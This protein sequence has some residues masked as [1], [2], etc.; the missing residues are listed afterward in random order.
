MDW[1]STFVRPGDPLI[2]GWTKL[3]PLDQLENRFI[4]PI[5]LVFHVSS[6]ALRKPLLRDLKASLANTIAKMPFLAASVVP[7]CEEQD[8][9]QLEI[10]DDAGVWFYSQELPEIDYYALERRGFPP[11]EFPLLSLMPEPR[12]HRRER[13]PVL[14][15]L[16]TF[17][18]SGLLL[19][20]NIHHSAMDGT[21]IGIFIKTFAKHAAA[22]SDGR[23]LSSEEAFPEEALDRSNII[24]GSGRKE[25]CDIPNYRLSK[26]YR[27]A[28]EQELIEAAIA[29]GDNPLLQKLQFS[30]WSVSDES[31]RAIRE[32]AMPPAKELPVLTE[33]A[34]ICAVL[35]RH[36]SRARQL[37]ARGIMTHSF[38]NTV[39][40]RRRM[41]PSLPLEYPGNAL[42]HAKTSAT[43]T[44]VDSAEPGMLYKLAKQITDAIDWWTPER[45]W[46]LIGAIESSE[47][48]SKIEPNMDNFQ[49]PDLEVTSTA[50][51]GHIFS[52]DWG[53][54]LGR[55]KAFRFVY[56]PVKDGWV[57]VLPQRK[58]AGIELIMGLEKSSI[59]NLR[60]D[61]EWL[62][63]AKEIL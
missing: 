16:A 50:A 38:I 41:D 59:Q 56:A 49:G 63:L 51:L 14:T 40:I 27:C 17:I 20:L 35:W 34:I 15:V 61:K 37:S 25:V 28:V 3:S 44:D 29:G 26:K 45:I 30:H 33:H 18:A 4:V 5:V 55:L 31:I 48:V 1:Q 58:G 53:C 12:V 23:F 2:P 24:G 22:L 21:G 52:V 10:S 32:A 42:V 46:E 9:I 54:G 60:Q 13:S 43:T 19:T 47:K 6:P 11:P 36:I 39:N 57:C 62:Q 7:D 8:T